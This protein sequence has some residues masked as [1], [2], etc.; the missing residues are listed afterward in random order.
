MTGI[1][2]QNPFAFSEANTRHLIGSFFE[3]LLK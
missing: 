3:F 2:A 1:T